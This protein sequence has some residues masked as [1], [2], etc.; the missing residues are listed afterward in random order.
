MRDE[1]ILFENI[2]SE[3]VVKIFG[4]VM[5]WGMQPN[6]ITFNKH[7]FDRVKQRYV[8]KNSIYDTI[9]SGKII[10]FH[11]KGYSPRVLI[12]K[13]LK[14]QTK[15]LCVVLDIECGRVYTVFFN[16]SADKHETLRKE[17]YLEEMNVNEVIDECIKHN[18]K[19]K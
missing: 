16:H 9:I 14:N 1:R 15:D 2:D 5:T 12:R 3:G 18:N 10:E 7:C 17:L 4:L 8:D 13:R 19:N 6:N 11:V